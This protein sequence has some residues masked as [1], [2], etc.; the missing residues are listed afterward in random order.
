MHKRRFVSLI[1]GAGLMAFG[2]V[3]FASASPSTSSKA[4]AISAES[5]WPWEASGSVPAGT[6]GNDWEYPKG[7][8][9]DSQ[10]SYLKQINTGNVGKLAGRVESVVRSAELHG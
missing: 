6:A 4:T 5:A 8:L 1:L 2:V 3:S 9:G 7:D 10:F